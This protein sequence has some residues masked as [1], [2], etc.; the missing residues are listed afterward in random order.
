MNRVAAVLFGVAGVLTLVGT[1]MYTFLEPTYYDA[2]TF[3]D[4]VSVIGLSVALIVT[5]AA[6]VVLWRNPPVQRGALFLL[7]AGIGVTAMGIGNLL[8]DAFDIEAGVWGFLGGGLTML[9][10]LII[11]GISALTVDNPRRWSGLFL[12]FASSGAMLGLGLAMMGVSWILFG[13]WLAYEHRGFVIAQA[14]TVIPAAVAI[15]Y[16]YASD[17][18]LPG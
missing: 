16:L 15:Y 2:S 9:V 4:Y 6:L 17:L 7:F 5:G 10:S 13:L 14:L 12:L 1:A 18:T 11:A 3:T 8:E